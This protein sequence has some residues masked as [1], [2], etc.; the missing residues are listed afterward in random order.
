[1]TVSTTAITKPVARAM[2]TATAKKE[3]TGATATEAGATAAGADSSSHQANTYHHH[4]SSMTNGNTDTSDI[5]DYSHQQQ[6]LHQSQQQHQQ[7]HNPVAIIDTGYYADI[8]QQ[9]VCVCCS[10][11][12]NNGTVSHPIEPCIATQLHRKVQLDILGSR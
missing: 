5:H 7:Q 10:E 6:G 3:A 11:Y 8:V 4:Y 1:M 2:E 9:P 12:Y